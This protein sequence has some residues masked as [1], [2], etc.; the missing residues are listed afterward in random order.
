MSPKGSAAN[1]F[2]DIVTHLDQLATG[3]AANTADVP[4]LEG[5]HVKLVTLL[6][7]A[8]DLMAQQKTH[9]AA[10]QDLSRQIEAVLNQS[11][12]VSSFL[13]SGV[14]EHYGAQS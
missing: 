11:Q 14:R 1:S 2:A 3:L 12:K 10:K 4:H 6:G 9:K 5:H 7:S 13:R 8:H